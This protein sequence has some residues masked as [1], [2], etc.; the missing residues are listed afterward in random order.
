[1]RNRFSH[2]LLPT[3]LLLVCIVLGLF[4]IFSLGLTTQSVPSEDSPVSGLYTLSWKP[5]VFYYKGILSSEECDHILELAEPLVTRSMV[6]GENGDDVVDQ[7]RTS[8]GV[9][10]TGKLAQDDAVQKLARRIALWTKIPEEHGE[11][12]YLIRYQVG[13]EYKP[14]LDWFDPS[15]EGE[16]IGDNGQRIA[17]VLTYLN[18][19]TAGGETIFP[20]AQHGQ[21]EVKP[22]KGDAV[23]FWNIL[24]DMT[25]DHLSLHGGKPVEEGV[26]W[27][28]TRWIRS[29]SSLTLQK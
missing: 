7:A 19:P 28:M 17:T 11:A 22:V 25:E 26:K 15:T 20:S 16:H 27:A 13:E 3:L 9:F 21:I 4:V 18:T 23:L 10:L 14:H 6:V 29:K 12:F 8:S 5:R 2:S 24:A 1:M